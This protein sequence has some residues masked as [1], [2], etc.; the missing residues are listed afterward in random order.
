MDGLKAPGELS[1]EGNVSENWRRW[2]RALENYLLAI[3]LVLKK[4]DDAANVE[5]GKRQVAILLNQAGDEANEVFSQFEYTVG[6]GQDKL[7]DVLEKFE[8]YCNPIKNILY[9]TYVFWSLCQADGEPID[10][11]VKRL[12]TQ[13][14]KCEFGNM[15]DRML[16]CRIVFGLSDPKLKERLLRDSEMTLSKA[17]DDIHAAEMT[18]K[19]LVRIS[20]GD[21]SS[22]DAVG[23]TKFPAGRSLQ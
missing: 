22:I 12:K 11:F 7:A 14:A 18:K 4:D 19:Q 2:R 6:K 20:D 13:A 17:L 5:I 10:N 23:Q 16:L 8:E 1:F 9:E 15:K 3:N 21:K